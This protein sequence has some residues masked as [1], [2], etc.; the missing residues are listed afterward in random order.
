MAEHVD[1]PKVLGDIFESFIGAI[2]IDSGK[3]LLKVWQIVYSLMHIEFGNFFINRRV[4]RF[5]IVNAL[6]SIT[7]YLEFVA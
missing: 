2:Y 5:G 4:D 3:D 6:D 7:A 1:V